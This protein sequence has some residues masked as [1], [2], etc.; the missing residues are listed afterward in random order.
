MRKKEGAVG[1]L[2]LD[3]LE[4][5][6]AYRVDRKGGLTNDQFFKLV[7]ISDAVQATLKWV[8][9]QD[10]IDAGVSSWLKKQAKLAVLRREEKR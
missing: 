9:K 7:I 4:D 6:C 10:H 3:I 1:E 8:A 5:V 2:M